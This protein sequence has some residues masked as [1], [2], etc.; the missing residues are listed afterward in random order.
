MEK[1]RINKANQDKIYETMIQP[2]FL[3]G[4]ECWKCKNKMGKGFLQQKWV[5]Y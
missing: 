2:I 3:C 4:S 1:Q 5:G